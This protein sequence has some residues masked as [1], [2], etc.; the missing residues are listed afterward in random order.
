M[1]NQSFLI[2]A[3]SKK[4]GLIFGLFKPFDLILFGS[5][6]AVTFILLA[7]LPIS[8]LWGVVLTLL[9][10]CT[11][12][13]LVFPIPSYHNVRTLLQ[14]IFIY[15]KNRR[16]YIWRGWCYKYEQSDK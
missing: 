15:Y 3:N 12:G 13:M 2:P 10:I 1:I 6:T 8:K 9:P 16:K 11:T 7:I 14:E 5:G 4:S